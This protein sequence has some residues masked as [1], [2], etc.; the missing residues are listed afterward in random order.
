MKKNIFFVGAGGIGMAALERYFIAK[1]FNVAGYD[2]TPSALTHQLVKEGVDINYEGSVESIPTA[3]R[4]PDTT[5]VV[6][7]PAVPESLECLQWFRQNGF[8]V[9][10]RARLLGEVTRNSYSLCFAGTHG[11]TTTSSMAAHILTSTPQGG[12]NA[13]IGGVL[14]NYGSNCLL[15]P[16][17]NISVIEADEFDRSFHQLSPAIAVITA[18]DAD[19]LDIYGT[20]EEYIESF[21]HFTSLIKDGGFLVKHTGI[22]LQPRVN[23]SVKIFTYSGREGDD[24]DFQ[25]INI[26]RVDNRL[27]YDV[28]FP[29]GSRLT[30]LE[31]RL[32][33]R[34]NIDNSIA[35]IAAAWLAGN[36]NAAAVKDAIASYNGVE[37]RFEIRWEDKKGRMIIDDYAHH[38]QEI[39][40]S[41]KSLKEMFPERRLTVA[42]QPHLYTRTRD[43]ANEFAKALSTAD[44]VILID[45]YP[46][47]EKPIPGISS[48]TIFDLVTTQK[49]H[50]IA[51]ENFPYFIK[52]CNFEVLETLGAGDLPN[53]IPETIKLLEQQNLQ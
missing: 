16:E 49:K 52:N 27:R 10:K 47:R 40:S 48:K 4:N 24:A 41:I 33:V 51:K 34:V 43:F 13:F 53:Y 7:T 12:C 20:K 50:L 46:A 22:E 26:R 11:K 29:D 32:P 44:E 23:P 30:D 45:L 6:Y 5:L 2:L 17:S 35:A 38:P 8:E 15:N 14:R 3:F 37:R 18:T 36:F 42:F 28:S 31:L 19:H 39:E 1:G 21:N 9:V 25:A